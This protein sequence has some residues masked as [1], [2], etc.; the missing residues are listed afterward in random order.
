M[1]TTPRIRR[2]PPFVPH[3]RVNASAGSWCRGVKVERSA[4]RARK[5]L[6][7]CHSRHA[8]QVRAGVDVVFQR[9][10]LVG[11][12]PVLTNVQVG[13][14]SRL[15]VWRT[16]PVWFPDAERE[17]ALA[18]LRRVGIGELA[19]QRARSRRSGKSWRRRPTRPC[20]PTRRPRRSRRSTAG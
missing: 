7:I 3:P 17:R 6:A 9:F 18:A 13:S 12:F 5:R 16:I 11:R 10:N 20:P 1:E 19:A 14:L 8:R 4:Q 2:C 15:P